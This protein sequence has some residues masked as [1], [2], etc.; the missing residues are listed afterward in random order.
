MTDLTREGFA[1]AFAAYIFWGFAPLYFLL[2]EFANPSE[3]IVHRVLWSLLFML[4]ILWYR[5]DLGELFR[6]PARNYAWL[7]LSGI[8]LAANWWIFVWAL[9][10]ERVMETSVGYYI[11]PLVSVLLGVIVLGERLRSWQWVAVAIVALGMLNEIFNAGSI[12]LVALGL[13]F[14]FGFYGLVR[15]ALGV[16]AVVGLSVE[17]LLL[18]PF[19]FLG[20]WWLY[21]AELLR[22]P[23]QGMQ[24]WVYLA[25]GGLVTSLP[26]LWFNAAAVRLPLVVLGMI[27]YLA[28]SITL[29]L[30]VYYYGEPFTVHK[31][32]T[33]ACVWGGLALFSVE[34][35]LRYRKELAA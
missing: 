12:P 17:A 23:D 8:L 13:A 34:G 33:F 22:A 5:G 14:S 9:Q 25:L 3:I 32:I 11:N 15:K 24:G 29:L 4:A 28:P 1:Y 16:D 21:S 2:V 18:L 27:Q 31:A 35:L 19:A 26:L 7:V 10:N 20:G 30:A 6:M